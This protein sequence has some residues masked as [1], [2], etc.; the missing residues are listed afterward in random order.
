M[1]LVLIWEFIKILN[2]N[3][4][5]KEKLLSSLLNTSIYN[6]IIDK[7]REE[8]NK[9]EAKLSNVKAINE[10][11]LKKYDNINN[12]DELNNLLN[13]KEDEFNKANIKYTNINKELNN[14]KIEIQKFS[15]LN[16]LKIK[17][18]HYAKFQSK[19]IAN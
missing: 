9:L 11:T 5:D 3:S 2:S 14:L 10:N 18:L 17:F 19:N 6:K 15:N 7:L 1:V 8:N 16:S 12:I 13:I 4:N